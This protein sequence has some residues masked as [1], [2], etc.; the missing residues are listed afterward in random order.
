MTAGG[1]APAVLNAANEIAV[2][3]FLAGQIAFTDIAENAA[4]VLDSMNDFSAPGSLEDVIL[5]DRAARA[6]TRET[7]ELAH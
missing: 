3:A 2:A 5:V 7:M 6:R 1:S 4:R